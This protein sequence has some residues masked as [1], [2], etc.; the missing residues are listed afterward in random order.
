[1]SAAHDD[2]RVAQL[3]TISEARNLV[4]S[5][6]V[7]KSFDFDYPDLV[8]SAVERLRTKLTELDEA[9]DA[10]RTAIRSKP[11]EEAAA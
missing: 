6:D 9:D 2:Y 8:W 10:W 3:R 4:I 1:M 11:A 5:Y 7:A